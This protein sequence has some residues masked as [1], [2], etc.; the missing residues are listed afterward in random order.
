MT[1]S[2]R[3]QQEKIKNQMRDDIKGTQSVANQLTGKEEIGT[4][5]LRDSKKTDAKTTQPTA[6]VDKRKL[7][8]FLNFME[9]NYKESLLKVEL[10][11]KV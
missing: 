5:K 4:K 8:K 11:R 10:K 6:T 3:K 9:S 1:G 2:I 7:E